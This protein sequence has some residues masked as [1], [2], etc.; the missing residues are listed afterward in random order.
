MNNP[1]FH[2]F[3]A[4]MHSSR[5]VDGRGVFCVYNKRASKI[6]EDQTPQGTFGKTHLHTVTDTDGKKDTSLESDLSV[7]EGKASPIID[8]MV[9]MARNDK[10]PGLTREE[11]SVWDMYLY[12]QWKRVPDVHD[13]VAVLA[14]DPS[15][16]DEIFAELKVMFPDHDE[17]IDQLRHDPEEMRR[18]IKDGTAAAIRF[19]PG[20]VLKVLA[21]RGVIVARVAVLGASLA[22]GS[23]PVLRFGGDLRDPNTEMWLPV[24]SDVVVGIG[25]YGRKERLEHLTNQSAID[26]LN[27]ATAEQ[28]T[29]FAAAS[30]E[31]IVSLV[32][33]LLLT[34]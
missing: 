21:G 18:L 30:K 7:L 27:Q 5:F 23:R 9:S 3:V 8:K 1:K 11:R 15:E 28:S 25:G 4:Q 32:N 31:L 19:S 34:N 26:Q 24:A 16:W 13:Q 29:S 10:E 12:T 17:Q 20:E 6:L 33:H 2:H 14:G 22:I